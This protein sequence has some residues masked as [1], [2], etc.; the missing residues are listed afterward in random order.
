MDN[1]FSTKRLEKMQFVTLIY[2]FCVSV[3][4]VLSIILSNSEKEIH[5]ISD[6]VD[7]YQQVITINY[8]NTPL[9]L[10]KK[11]DGA[12]VDSNY[13]Y[14]LYSVL[15]NEGIQTGITEEDAF[16]RIVSWICNST[17]YDNSLVNSDWTDIIESGTVVCNGYAEIF[18]IMCQICGMQCYKVD[19]YLDDGL[20]AWNYVRI[21]DVWYWVDITTYDNNRTHLISQSLWENY[22]PRNFLLYYHDY[23]ESEADYFTD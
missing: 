6:R 20:H 21:N 23:D 18:Q 19:G 8:Q 1:N 2:L 4:V 17:T 22:V 15:R 11:E 14:Q 12:A 9:A 7:E 16:N 5:L 13:L 10:T 3:L